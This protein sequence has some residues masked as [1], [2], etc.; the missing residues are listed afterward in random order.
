LHW[1]AKEAEIRVQ[2]IL[3]KVIQALDIDLKS[4]FCGRI[5][6]GDDPRTDIRCI[7]LTSVFKALEHSDLFI[8]RTKKG[9][10]VEYG[11]LWAVD[12]AST[13]KRTVTVLIGYF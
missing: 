1:D 3:S 12:N 7:S 8:S 5:L 10:V 2:A 13:L 9:A 6:K 11:P 4:P